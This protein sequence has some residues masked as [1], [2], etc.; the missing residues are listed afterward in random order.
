MELK[1]SHKKILEY[2]QKYGKANT[3]KLSRHLGIDRNE[4]ID[5]IKDLTGKRLAFIK[6]GSV[7]INE[8]KYQKF[9][10]NKGSINTARAVSKPKAEKP[11]FRIQENKGIKKQRQ[12]KKEIEELQAKK[13][14]IAQQLAEEIRLLNSIR[15]EKTEIENIAAKAAEKERF[16]SQK[17]EEM[18]KRKESV[19]AAEKKLGD[20]KEA[21]RKEQEDIKKQKENKEIKPKRKGAVKK[22]KL[23]RGKK[24][25][26]E[27]RT[28]RLRKEKQEKLENWLRQAKLE[29]E[30][31]KVEIELASMSH[32]ASK[33]R[34]LEASAAKLRNMIDWKMRKLRDEA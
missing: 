5:L 27:V 12:L 23:K 13:A 25:S 17:E 32:N 3:F 24:K 11:K 29:I 8:I 14:D 19:S 10:E 30:R 6:H 9:I 31:L 16:L 1:A 20:D 34:S 4:L 18:K 21:L 33:I 28:K 26:K 2:L 15:E 22:A 7:L